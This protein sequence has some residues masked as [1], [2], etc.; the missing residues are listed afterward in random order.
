MSTG[1]NS[2]RQPPT[3]FHLVLGYYCQKVLVR[4]KTALRS[5]SEA[6][7]MFTAG[8]DFVDAHLAL[9]E[10]SLRQWAPKFTAVV[11]SVWGGAWL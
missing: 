6:T 5:Q 8:N 4:H 11:I 7:E 1:V 10:M 3:I 9:S 2:T